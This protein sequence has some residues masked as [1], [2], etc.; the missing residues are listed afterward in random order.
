MKEKEVGIQD[1]IGYIEERFNN[2]A[3]KFLEDMKNVPSFSEI[4]DPPVSEFVWGLGNWVT[5]FLE[6]A[7]ESK[8]YFGSKGPEVK[9]TKI[10]E[11]LPTGTKNSCDSWSAGM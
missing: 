11:L 4:L 5:G 1:A 7:F 8:R 9:S 3:M 10:V 6:W 2:V